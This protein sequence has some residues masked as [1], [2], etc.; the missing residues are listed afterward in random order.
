M[1]YFKQFDLLPGGQ[2]AYRTGHSCET[3]LL[4]IHL[5]LIA[6]SDGGNISLLAML[7]LSFAF[8]CMNHFILLLGLHHNFG[9]GTAIVEWFTVIPHRERAAGQV[10]H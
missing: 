7:D 3:A 5:D 4:R 6:A 2:L 8:D 1:V 9:L 10:S